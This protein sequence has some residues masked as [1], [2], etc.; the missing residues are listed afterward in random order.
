MG[1]KQTSMHWLKTLQ[2]YNI[3]SVCFFVILGLD[4]RI[5]FL[6]TDSRS[7]RE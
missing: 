1:E 5:S 7:S 6:K 3:V 4:P 2:D